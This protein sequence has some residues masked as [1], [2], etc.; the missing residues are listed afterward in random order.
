MC[1]YMPAAC[2]RI[3]YIDRLI[4][5]VNYKKSDILTPRS[6]PS[7]SPQLFRDSEA[8]VKSPANFWSLPVDINSIVEAEIEDTYVTNT[9]FSFVIRS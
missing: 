3:S 2:K 6:S 1:A 5:K 8:R 7:P 9:V 4:T